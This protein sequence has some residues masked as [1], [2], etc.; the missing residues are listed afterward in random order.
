MTHGQKYQRLREAAIIALLSHA[1][2]SDA[3]K[4]IGISER[5]L[6]KWMQKEDFAESVR[7]LR[8]QV[9]EAGASRL[10]G[11]VSKAIETLEAGLQSKKA[12]DRTRAARA[13]L[14]FRERMDRDDL[15]EKAA[16]LERKLAEMQNSASP[17]VILAS[18]VTIS[19]SAIEGILGIQR[20]LQTRKAPT[21]EVID[22]VPALPAPAAT[23]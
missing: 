17:K 21:A 19:R 7:T 23:E 5:G 15:R 9:L 22:H 8:R 1:S 14:E 3:A 16:A 6:R 12:A 2:L 13:I 18:S 11:L 10:T 20:D 4:S